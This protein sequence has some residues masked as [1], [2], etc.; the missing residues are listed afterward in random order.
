M[1]VGAP[2]LLKAAKAGIPAAVLF[3]FGLYACL[4]GAKI[5]VA[6]LVAR[7]R[8]FLKSQRYVWVNRVLGAILTVFALLFLRDGLR[9][10]GIVSPN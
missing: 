9:F 8:S 4:I 3:I 7:S 2:T 1:V 10:L 6:W 5:L